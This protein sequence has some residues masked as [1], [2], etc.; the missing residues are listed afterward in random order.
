MTPPTYLSVSNSQTI[1]ATPGVD[2]A[3]SDQEAVYCSGLGFNIFQLIGD[4]SVSI[5][6]ATYKFVSTDPVTRYSTYV[7]SCPNGNKQCTCGT[8]NYLGSQ[9]HLWAEEFT[10]WNSVQGCFFINLVRYKDGPPAVP[11]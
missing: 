11:M 7:L 10:L 8:T 3:E 1:N 5:K 9:A 6:V 2:Y 4:L